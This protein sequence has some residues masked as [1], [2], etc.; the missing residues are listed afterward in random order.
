MT[1]TYKPLV[2]SQWDA[3]V[4]EEFIFSK[5]AFPFSKKNPSRKIRFVLPPASSQAS[6]GFS[7]LLNAGEQHVH[8]AL[9]PTTESHFI[10]SLSAF[11]GAEAVPKDFLNAVVGYCSRE[12]IDSLEFFLQ[13]PLSLSEQAAA[14]NNAVEQ[15]TIHCEVLNEQDEIELQGAITFPLPLLEKMIAKAAALPRAERSDLGACTFPGELLV[16]I[17][18]LSL[19]QWEKLK[20]GDL[21]FFKEPS[22]CVTGE[23]FFY[24]KNGQK[25]AAA[26]D[27]KQLQGLVQPFKKVALADFVPEKLILPASAAGLEKKAECVSLSECDAIE[28]ALS[29]CTLSLTLD[30]MASLAKTKKLTH[31]PLLVPSI[32][33]L[34]Q[35]KQV[36]AGEL[37]EIHGQ[38]AIFVNQL[39][40][41]NFK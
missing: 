16:G 39:A 10:K 27:A 7:F 3:K 12:I 11:G 15:K 33:I 19:A 30:E 25:L 1:T 23:G 32:K 13:V 36:G 14:T 37:V 9:E 29:A 31:P 24:F 26:L 40:E 5:R 8:V 34:I 41:L 28:L 6:A 21:L 18:S 35:G 4:L 17:I 2:L 22:A 20:P 38:H